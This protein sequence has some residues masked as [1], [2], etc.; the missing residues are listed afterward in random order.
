VTKFRST[1]PLI[2]SLAI[3]AATLFPARSTIP[4]LHGD[5]AWVGL[6]ASEILHG[7]RPIVGM[8]NYTGPVHQ[9]LVAILFHFFGSSVSIL[10]LATPITSLITLILFHRVIKRLFHES[11]AN[12]SV[13][14]LVSAPFFT[15]YGRLANE[16]FAL[17]PFLAVTG[18]FLIIET[19]GKS[20]TLSNFLSFLSGICLGLG[21]WN[22]AIFAAFPAA[23]FLAALARRGTALFRSPQ[24]Y[25]S[26]LGLV[27]VLG[28][29]I[30]LG[31]APDIGLN[32]RLHVALL[33]RLIE[34]PSVFLQLAHGDLL[35][36]R[37]AGQVIWKTPNL[38]VI[39]VILA[40]IA[41]FTNK[42]RDPLQLNQFEI[43]TIIFAA[44]LF[45]GTLFL[46]PSN[47][48]RYFLLLL[49]L[50]PLFLAFALAEIFQISSLR[51][52]APSIFAILILLQLSRTGV[53]YFFSQATTGGRPSSFLLGSQEETSNHF[54]R[55]DSL[56]QEL[57]AQ[58]TKNIYAESL[59]AWPLQ[60]YDLDNHHFNG[61]VT[62]DL[63]PTKPA[64][65]IHSAKTRAVLYAGGIRQTGPDRFPDFKVLSQDS[66]FIIMAPN[67]PPP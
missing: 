30:S 65:R 3:G 4:G 52:F 15:G 28:L 12:S 61:V 39:I 64:Q 59:L 49:Y 44:A 21:V 51:P 16:V 23:L 36:Q 46:C 37:F 13:L 2:L 29:R 53:N 34:W 58:N 17:N 40:L 22:H 67:L 9:Y 42:R 27:M 26:I 24:L 60:F 56:Y 5:E 48:D 62:E 38:V 11:V 54:M 6:R 20:L 66:R 7:A 31:S 14:L 41:R 10:R 47:S 33:H 63:T 8:N 55:T 35:Y 18:I 1:A 19:P 57:A 50:V 25:A 45:L 43:A 32:A